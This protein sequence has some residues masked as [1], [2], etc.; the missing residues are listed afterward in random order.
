LNHPNIIKLHSTFISDEV[1]VIVLPYFDDDL[2]TFLQSFAPLSLAVTQ[3]ISY[4][5]LKGLCYLHEEMHVIHRDIK[6]NN[7]LVHYRS[8]ETPIHVVLTDFGSAKQ[9]SKKRENKKEK[10]QEKEKI[11]NQVTVHYDEKKK[12]SL[13]AT[14]SSP[15]SISISHNHNQEWD[16]E[17]CYPNKG[18]KLDNENIEE[19]VSNLKDEHEQ[20]KWQKKEQEGEENDEDDN[21]DETQEKWTPQVVVRQYR[22]PELLL[23]HV[24]YDYGI[25]VWA[26]G[27]V[28]AQ[29]TF[30]DPS[31]FL[32]DGNADIN[33]FSN[34]IET[35]QGDINCLSGIGVFDEMFEMN[36]C[37]KR[38][39]NEFVPNLNKNGQDLIQKLLTYHP[40]SRIAANEAL[41][42]VFFSRF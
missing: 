10:E 15:M 12:E 8:T 14:P 34:I 9:V 11:T 5:V 25:D 36:N 27:C 31:R 16:I 19:K 1:L 17:N 28:L 2:S 30:E 41:Q 23:G 20:E 29:M 4:Q 39:A 37:P 13:C 33:V 35:L 6:P 32:F 22:S 3:S 7:I 26:F 21:D 38:P 18:I 42:H 40:G 24:S